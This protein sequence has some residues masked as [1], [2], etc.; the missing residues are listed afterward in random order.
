[1]T[2]ETLVNLDIR[3]AEAGRSLG[4]S[5]KDEKVLNDALAVLEEHGPYAM[6]LY[7]RARHNN[8]ASDFERPLVDLLKETLK[9]DGKDILDIVKSVADDLDALLF[10]RDLL[11]NA[12]IYARFHLK[13]RGGR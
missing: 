5:I 1:M 6:F 7:V 12:L 2:P 9:R 13:A 4:E 11:R 8:V 3:C 10:A